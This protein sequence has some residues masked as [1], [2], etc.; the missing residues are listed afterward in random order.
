M[1]ILEAKRCTPVDFDILIEAKQLRDVDELYLIHRQAW[2][3]NIVQATRRNGKPRYR[4]FDKFFD[5]EGLIEKVKYG[6]K[7]V[8]EKTQM[9][10]MN[11]KLSAFR[12]KQR[13]K[14]EQEEGGKA[15]GTVNDS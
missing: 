4:T 13:L 1:T 2:A 11:L 10:D 6:E 15:N 5:Y 9:A 12:K 3:N 14:R 8:N 7:V